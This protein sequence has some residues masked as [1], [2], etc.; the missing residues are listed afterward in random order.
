MS[1]LNTNAWK[2]PPRAKKRIQ[3][4]QIYKFYNNKE[5]EREQD[6]MSYAPELMCT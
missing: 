6:D 4:N 2:K 3:T 5:V 1:K